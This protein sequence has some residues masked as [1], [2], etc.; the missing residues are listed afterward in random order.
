MVSKM[1][2]I[3]IYSGNAKTNMLRYGQSKIIQ[4]GCAK[5]KRKNEPI[6]ANATKIEISLVDS[7][8]K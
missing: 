7:F 8:L 1:Q 2:F 3:F 4:Y 6:P 5:L